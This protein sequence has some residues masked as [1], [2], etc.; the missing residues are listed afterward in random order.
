MLLTKG[1]LYEL[2]E[3]C[4]EYEKSIYTFVDF[5]SVCRGS[6]KKM[7]RMRVKKEIFADPVEIYG[8]SNQIDIVNLSD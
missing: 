2:K 1:S 4:N 7:R 8:N 6:D 5:E 3:H